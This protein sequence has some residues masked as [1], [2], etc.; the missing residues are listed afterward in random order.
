MSVVRDAV[1]VGAGWS[2]LKAATELSEAGFDVLVLE[3]SRGPGGRSAT[4]RA[5]GARFDH[6]AQYFTA[7]SAAFG[8][9]LQQWRDDGLV[10]AWRPRLAVLGDRDQHH[11]PEDTLR[12]VAVPGMNAVCKYLAESLDCRYE[13]RVAEL[14]FDEIW[15][16]TLAD[17]EVIDARRL[18]LT[19][20]PAQ[21]AALLGATDPLYDRL[22]GV[23]FAP[24]I[25]AM[26]SFDEP[27]DPGFDAAFVNVDSPLSWVACN[28]TK[29]GRNGHDWVLHATATWSHDHLKQDFDALAD[30]LADAFSWI[31]DRSLPAM[32]VRT[33]H[34]W[35]YAQALEPADDGAIFDAERRLAIAGDWLAGSRIE[36]A[37]TSGRKAGQ[38]IAGI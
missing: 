36:G 5:D 6:G 29:P 19:A 27:F 22:A 11:D 35:R 32:R 20:P 10:Q 30:R 31:V 25:T 21:T 23:A 7:R 37:W 15:R 4:R 18:V 17:G 8:R 3:K 2:G 24:C 1:V 38:A 12:F 33:A 34:R 14:R 28:S 26:L 16:L 13:S 9:R